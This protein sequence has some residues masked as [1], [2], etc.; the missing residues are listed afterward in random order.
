M[1]KKN[2]NNINTGVIRIVLFIVLIV[3]L[4]LSTTL[5]SALK[6]EQTYDVTA[7]NDKPEEFKSIEEICQYYQCDLIETSIKI[8]D[9]D[10]IL[11]NSNALTN[12][13]YLKFGKLLYEDDEHGNEE[14][15]TSLINDVEKLL[16][17]EHTKL[18]DK[19]NNINI[20]IFC[21]EK[22]ILKVIING[23]EDYFGYMDRINSGKTFEE[24][25]ETDVTVDSIEL[26]NLI[27]F[28]WNKSALNLGNDYVL[29]QNFKCYF[30]KGIE[31]REY[32]D[33]V[34]AI[35]FT[36][37]YTKPI[38]CGIINNNDINYKK[39]AIGE[40]TF[41]SETS[42]VLGY[43]SK[44]FYAFVTEKEVIIVRR[45]TPAYDE[46]AKISLDYKNDAI[47]I[48]DYMNK[49]TTIWPD[50]D[51]FY[52][53]ENSFRLTYSTK[54]IE[55]K[56][57]YE[58]VD[59]V[60]IYNNCLL[61]EAT[62]NSLLDSDKFLA[63]QKIDS[64]AQYTIEIAEKRN[65]YLSKCEEFIKQYKTDENPLTNS[66]YG[67]YADYS[68]SGN[69]YKIYFIDKLD[70]SPNR[71]ITENISSF[72]WLNDETLIYSVKNRGI[73]YINLLTGKRG[74][75]LTGEDEFNILSFANGLLRYDD[76]KVRI[77]QEN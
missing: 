68:A 28:K 59:Q 33:K 18:I 38:I 12:E 13:I 10:N 53:G 40:P 16:R 57:N 45:Y 3:F 7:I 29:F 54:G 60:V 1:Q 34:N 39:A 48:N 61:D 19:Q 55:I 73:Y 69:I 42:E 77:E 67:L 63:Q 74:T 5:I 8:D 70:Q 9:E 14:Y 52:M 58:Q 11:T 46:F 44:E 36:K 26:Q 62:L 35:I 64:V 49:I 4:A 65:A 30:D 20:E 25:K 76:K 56:D 75:V 41:T 32:D 43:K 72:A 47:D 50:Y 71:E 66:R 15:Y 37:N 31:I 17:Y 23:K 21:E 51:E 22:A 27:K 6:T 2:K 24:I